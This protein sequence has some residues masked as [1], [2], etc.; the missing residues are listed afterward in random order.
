[1]IYY[2]LVLNKPS[3][4]KIYQWILLQN[5]WKYNRI[6]QNNVPFWGQQWRQDDSVLTFQIVNR[7]Y[8]NI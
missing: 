8:C 1:M 3:A 2:K 5:M 6:P 4:S 7:T